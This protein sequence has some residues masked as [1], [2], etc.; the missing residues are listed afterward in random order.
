MKT[1]SKFMLCC[2][3]QSG[4]LHA[5]MYSFIYLV[6]FLLTIELILKINANI[7]HYLTNAKIIQ[8]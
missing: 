1:L 6:K 8:R 5:T 2:K 3:L 4:F 7:F